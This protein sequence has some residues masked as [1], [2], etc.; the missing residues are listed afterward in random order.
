MKHGQLTILILGYFIG[1]VAYML[2]YHAIG[3]VNF[4]PWLGVF[5]Y[6]LQYGLFFALAQGLVKQTYYSLDIFSLLF[7]RTYVVFKFIFFSLL[8]NS[9]MPTYIKWLDSKLISTIL[10]LSIILFTLALTVINHDRY[11]KLLG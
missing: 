5:Y 2:S 10:S 9:D 1:S 11:K 4:N 3:Y 7:F 6:L 8:I